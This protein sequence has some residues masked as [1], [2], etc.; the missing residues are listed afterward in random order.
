M[1]SPSRV[2]A[3]LDLFTPERP[4]WTTEDINQEL[5]YTRPTGYRYVK[6]LVDAGFLQKVGAGRYA[7]GGRIVVLDYIQRQTD[8]VFLAAAPVMHQLNDETGLD[9]VLSMMFNGQVV[10]THRVAATTNLR[11]AYSRGRVRPLF[12]GAAAKVLVAQL[13]RAQLAKLYEAHAAEAAAQGVGTSWT[14]FR[15]NFARIR[16]RGF[17][18]S[19]GELESDVGGAAV[20]VASPEGDLT[21]ALALVATIPTL[22][23]LGEQRLRRWLDA[24]AKTVHARFAHDDGDDQRRLLTQAKGA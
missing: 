6:E 21:A 16:R 8:P 14:A 20:P 19:L 23:A 24:A 1:S 5:G 4:V 15:D 13:P 17:H 18:F 10:D 9:V 7:L 3:V 12:Q 2:F 11:L 22:E